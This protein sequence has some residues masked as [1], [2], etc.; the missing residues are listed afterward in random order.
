M[1]D[2]EPPD[3]TRM[4]RLVSR[5]FTPRTVEAL[6]P[7]VEA[8]VNGLIDDFGGRGR[9]RSHRRLRRTAAG[10]RHRRAARAS[11]RRI[12]TCSGP[13]RRD[14]CLMYELNPPDESARKAVT[15]S[16]EFSAYL[17]D[18]LADRRAHPGDDLISGLAAVVDD[19][20]TLTEQELDRDVRA[21]PERGARGV[22]Q[23]RRER[24]V[25]AV[26]ASRRTRGDCGPNPALMPTAIE[27]LLRFDTPL[28]LFER[29]VLEPVEVQGVT[30]ERGQEVAHAVRVGESRSGG[31]RPGRTSSTSRATR[32]RTSRS[33]PGSTTASARRSPSSSSGSRS[34]RSCDGC[35]V[36][37][38]SRRRAGSRRSSCAVCASSASESE[39]PRAV[40][41]AR[42]LVH[43]RDVGRGAGPLAEPA[44]G[45]PRRR[46][47][48]AGPR[49]EP[50]R[51]RLHDGRPH[52]R[53]SCPRSSGCGPEFVSL[54]IGVN[55][56]VQAVPLSAVRGERRRRSSTRSSAGP[57]EADRDCR[58]PG[59]HG[60]AGG[61]DFGDPARSS[62][63][64]SSRSTPRWR[65]SPRARGSRTSTS[66]TV[67]ARAA[68]DR[69]LVAADGLHPS[70]AQYARW[71]E[72][73][74]P[75]VEGLVGA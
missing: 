9:G 41:R 18:L 68:E 21:A 50:R 37:S 60:H 43:D 59:L 63:R 44:R 56:V 55:D 42:R 36:S 47:A 33:V 31:L 1:L 16:L 20:D 35:R 8:I 71:V 34:R 54:L 69:S 30:L 26:P 53:T 62:A 48:A 2:L 66:S 46:P 6:R 24:L 32:T 40:R 10:D 28:S 74:A 65:R 27:E 73:I 57:G 45:A 4:R 49:R 67:S 3:H 12:G 19:G 72:R 61:A 7:Q 58:R 70:G 13:G 14:I 25:D 64:R 23:R 51:E 39:P 15:A 5:A 11:P 52:P 29:W 22:G 75:V 38:W 17:R